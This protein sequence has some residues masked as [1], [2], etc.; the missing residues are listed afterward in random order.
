MGESRTQQQAFWAALRNALIGF[1]GSRR[2]DCVHFCLTL[3]IRVWLLCP[4]FCPHSLVL[5]F[6]CKLDAEDCISAFPYE[7]EALHWLFA[8]IY[9]SFLSA[10][11]WW[12]CAEGEIRRFPW[13]SYTIYT[14]VWTSSGIPLLSLI[15]SYLSIEQG[16]SQ[17]CAGQVMSILL[18][19]GTLQV[20]KR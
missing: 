20:E 13:W 1:S 12:E 18:F 17:S 11:Y 3:S 16:V 6:F 7:R 15:K 9:W 14:N 19:I 8:G 4:H 2:V 10:Y 5:M